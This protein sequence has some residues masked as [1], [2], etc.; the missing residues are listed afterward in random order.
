MPFFCR[1]RLFFLGVVQCNR[2]RSEWNESDM[3][4]VYTSAITHT[5]ICH[6]NTGRAHATNTYMPLARTLLLR[7]LTFTLLV[8]AILIQLSTM[9]IKTH[10]V[11]TPTI[12]ANRIVCGSVSVYYFDFSCG[13][14]LFIYSP[15]QSQ[16][17]QN[18]LLQHFK[19]MDSSYWIMG[20]NIH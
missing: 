2:K 1:F 4:N 8:I 19:L 16:F 5:K 7:A 11:E 6:T 9:L 13:M 17:D 10:T 20:D 15:V 12:A 18:S 3:S 14:E